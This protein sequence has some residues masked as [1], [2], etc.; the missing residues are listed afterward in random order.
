[1]TKFVSGTARVEEDP[2]FRKQKPIPEIVEG[3]HA[4]AARRLRQKYRNNRPP[5]EMIGIKRNTNRMMGG[6]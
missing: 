3:V 5:Q 1:M 6:D 2:A 4:H